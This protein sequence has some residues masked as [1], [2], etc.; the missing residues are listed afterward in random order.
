VAVFSF[1]MAVGK[2]REQPNTGQELVFHLQ[3]WVVAY[4]TKTLGKGENIRK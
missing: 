4:S 1:F 2:I 3:G